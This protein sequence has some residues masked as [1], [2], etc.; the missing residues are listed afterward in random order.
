[1]PRVTLLQTNFT[2]GELSPRMYGRVDVARYQN[3]ARQIRNGRVLLQGGVIRDWGTRYLGQ[4][5]N[6]AVTGRLVPFVFNR[7]QAFMLEWGNLTLR[8]WRANGTLVES[9][10]G[11]PYVLTTP[12][13]SAQVAEFDYTQGADTMILWHESVAPYRLVRYAD[14][15]WLLE[16]VP[17]V[18]MPTDEIGERI[19]VTGT[20]SAATVGTGRTLTAAAARFKP[21]DV[22]RSVTAGAG[23]ATITAY[24]STTQ[25]TVTIT[26]AFAGTSLAANGWII[27]ESPRAT[28]TPSAVGPVGG[29]VNLTAGSSTLGAVKVI[30]GLSWTGGTVTV[31]CTGHGYATSDVVVVSGVDVPAFN[32]T[33][34]ITVVDPNTFTYSGGNATPPST[35]GQVQKVQPAPGCWKAEH[36]GAYVRIN[37]GLLKI[38]SLTSDTIAVCTVLIALSGT[39]AAPADAWAMEFAVWNAVDGYPRTG[40][41]WEQRLVAGGSPRYPQTVWGS[42]TGERFNFARGV[43]DDQGFAFTLPSD[44][45][46]PIAWIASVRTLVALTLGG[47]FTLQGGIEKPITPTNIQIRARSNHGC[48]L[49]RPVRVGREEI[50]VQRAARKVRALSYNATNDDYAAPE[51]TSL[52][53][54]VTVSGVREL[55]WQRSPEPWLYARLADGTLSICTYELQDENVVAWVRRDFGTDACEAIAQLPDSDGN[56][57]VWTIVRRTVSGATRRYVERFS[58]QAY[59]DAELALTSGTPAT[60]WSGLSHLEGRTVDVV[61]DESDAGQF[62][63]AGG[64]ITLTQAASSVRIGLPFTTRV[65]MLTP[66]LQM[67]EGSAQGNSMRI[68]EVTLRFLETTGGKVNGQVIPARQLDTPTLDLPPSSLTGLERVETLGWDRG[69]AE[70]VIEQDRPMPFHLLNVVR[71]VTVNT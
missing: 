27:G 62:T 5:H 38:A 20:L 37:G 49:V 34:T 21:A 61:A 7:S 60:V 18:D 12:Y 4:T 23:L 26:R 66:E 40:T 46:N 63:V 69:E 53:E 65:E 52:A 14:D 47:E 29:T 30:G 59:A 56:E 19:S 39:T 51:I 2:A 10:P 32:G 67:G 16:A 48:A 36:V 1:M 58:S 13:T 28:A 54:H 71:K 45:V 57:T 6:M 50:F 9:S 15:N 42:W 55:A 43:A 44:E 8:I 22:G 35:L 41:L 17:F 33:F 68:G 64:S 24:T 31:T 70:L 25:V 3:G 11:V